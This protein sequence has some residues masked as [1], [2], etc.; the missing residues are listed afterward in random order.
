MNAHPTATA[1]ATNSITSGL[2]WFSDH[3]EAFNAG[4]TDGDS[5]VPQLGHQA[6]LRIGV[7]HALGGAGGDTFDALESIAAVAERSLTAAFVF[8]GQRTFIE[9]LL[10]SPNAGLRERWLPALLA[11]EFAGATGLSNAMKFLSGIESIQIAATPHQ[12]GWRLNGH[13]PWVTNLR[14]AGF[15]VA[16][17]VAPDNGAAPAVVAF[18]DRQPGVR[19][20]A[21]LDLVALR[22]SNTAAIA[23]DAVEIGP[24]DV[25]HPDARTFCPH[26]RPAF[27]SL[28]LGMSIGLARA[29]LQTARTLGKGAHGVLLPRAE[30]V[31]N[32]LESIV[33]SVREGLATERFRSDPAALFRIRIRLAEIVQVALGLELDATGGRAYLR[34]HNRDFARRWLEA[35]FVP[36]I[37]PSLTQLQGELA[38]HA[39]TCAA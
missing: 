10:Q 6:L 14:K 35:A 11:G 21:D 23:I 17:A 15:V 18:T 20:S 25:I 29:A 1:T 36:V 5:I 19:R 37:T 33:G 8:W 4:T 24:E 26:V 31:A 7:P 9:Y 3:A 32:E 34:D 13:L 2:G 39:G 38:K 22:A 30:T 27:L 12:H 28:Q 16:A